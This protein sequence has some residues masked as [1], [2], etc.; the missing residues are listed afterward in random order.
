MVAAAVT[1]FGFVTRIP[2]AP[3]PLA[4]VVVAVAWYLRTAY[5]LDHRV[6]PPESVW[7]LNRTVA[8]CFG[9]GV[10]AVAMLS[11]LAS[12]DQSNYFVH[13]TIDMLLGMVAPI[14]LALGSPL[15]LAHEAAGADGR[16]A[17]SRVLASRSVRVVSHPVTA[18][19]IFGASLFAQYYSPWFRVARGNE[20]LLQLGHLELLVAGCLL[21]W[22]V[23][24]AD[25]IAR[26]LPPGLR[27]A[28]IMFALPFYTVF[29]MGLDSL[30][31]VI[32]PG[33][34]IA[35]VHG[36]GDIIWSAG[37]VIGLAASAGILYHWMMAD[38]RRA[39]L[40]ESADADALGM[41]AALWR[42]SRLLAKPEEVR[43]AERVAALK[44]ETVAA[45]GRPGEQA[46]PPG[47]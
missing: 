32:A 40:D 5:D 26:R 16:Q 27:I 44:A 21:I 4:V 10:V 2:F 3:L 43:E 46:G 24:G 41:Q 25:P 37:E 38:L 34:T 28:D 39:R 14:F 1:P 31:S 22:P 20:T 18:W 12:W 8:F 33:I 35:G 13:G 6:D 42:V 45:T 36:A 29:G 15:T 19:V 11:G 23:V 7:P 47:Q 9:M 30:N 17:L